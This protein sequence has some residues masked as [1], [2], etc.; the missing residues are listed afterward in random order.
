[1]RCLL[2]LLLLFPAVLPAQVTPLPN[3]HAHNDYE[4]ERPLLDALAQGFTSVEVDVHLVEGELYVSHDAPEVLEATKTLEKLYL[5]PLSERVE[6]NGG[7]VYPNYEGDFY[8]MIDVKTAAEPTLTAILETLKSYESMLT[9]T[10]GKLITKRAVRVFISGNRDKERIL[11]A[12]PAWVALDGRPDDLGKG[13]EAAV[14]PVI[15]DRYWNHLKWRGEGPMPKAEHKHLKSLVRRT[16]A[17]GKKLRL[18]ASPENKKVWKA[19]SKAGV[20]FI[21]TDELVELRKFLLKQKR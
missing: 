13:N 10:K 1:M 20:D 14:M 9:I 6:Q 19:L 11:T 16:H 21:N 8:L 18:W 5:Q 12:N 15:S 2:F 3:A 7:L 4:H 17:E